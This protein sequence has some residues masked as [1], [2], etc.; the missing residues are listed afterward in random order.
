ML[1]H[2][3]SSVRD[4]NDMQSGDMQ[5]HRKKTIENMQMPRNAE[6]KK[7]VT[8]DTNSEINGYCVETMIDLDQE[9]KQEDV[10]DVLLNSSNIPKLEMSDEMLDNKIWKQSKTNKM[11]KHRMSKCIV[12]QYCG[13]TLSH[14]SLKSHIQSQH[15]KTKSFKCKECD[16][17][18]TTETGRYKHSKRMHTK[19][20]DGQEMEFICEL[21]GKTYKNSLSLYHHAYQHSYKRKSVKPPSDDTDKHTCG[22]CGKVYNF[23][24]A[25]YM[26]IRKHDEYG[27][28]LL[29]ICECGKRFAFKSMFL[30]HQ[31]FHGVS[32]PFPCSQCNKRFKTKNTMQTHLNKTHVTVRRYVCNL[33]GDSFKQ[34]HHLAQHMVH[35][36]DARPFACTLCDKAYKVKHDLKLHCRRVHQME[37]VANVKTEQ[38]TPT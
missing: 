37:L 24:S 15:E 26:H 14:H 6:T 22:Y 34:S 18:F 7:F 4:A 1:P 25:L 29:Y 5:S 16:L 31:P 23:K 35:H 9:V 21:C 8:S 2:E 38:M 30:K 12:C 17:S 19:S 3:V 36:S 32:R 20:S 13:I 33:C 11:R 28:A 10:L 27:K